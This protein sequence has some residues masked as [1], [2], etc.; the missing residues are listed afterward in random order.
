MCCFFCAYPQIELGRG[1]RFAAEHLTPEA[2]HWQQHAALALYAQKLAQPIAP[3][4]QM[5]LPSPA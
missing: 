3:D 4:P 2:M 1:D 5:V